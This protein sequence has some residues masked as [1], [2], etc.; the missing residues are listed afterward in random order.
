[1]QQI[2]FKMRF[3]GPKNSKDEKF[4]DLKLFKNRNLENYLQNGVCENYFQK[5]K[6]MK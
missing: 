2:L 4:G 5:S 3:L 6:M 1:M